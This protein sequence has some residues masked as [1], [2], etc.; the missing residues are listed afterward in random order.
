MYIL[1][2]KDEGSEFKKTMLHDLSSEIERKNELKDRRNQ[3]LENLRQI[4]IT[5]IKCQEKVVKTKT[6]L[7]TLF[8][9]IAMD[10]LVKELAHLNEVDWMAFKI[11]NSTQLENII[12]GVD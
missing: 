8:Q 11:E 10:D 3:F 1:R 2:I 7:Q 4:A 12:F 5:R 6:R 9:N